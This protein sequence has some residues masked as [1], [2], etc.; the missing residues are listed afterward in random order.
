MRALADRRL[1]E[2]YRRWIDRA[3]A[4]PPEVVMLPRTIDVGGDA[5]LLVALTLPMG[6]VG[7]FFLMM[8]SRVQPA[9]DGWPPFLFTGLVGVGLWIAPVLL[10]RR[11]VRTVGASADRQR[12]VLRQGIFIGAEGALVRM[13]PDSC[14]PI[15]ADR[16]VS[17]KL[18]Q[19]LHP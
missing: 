15:P 7:A 9:T 6:V 1:P 11:L 4:L 8:A 12:G 10:L 19:P 13:E 5:V 14:H 16:F 2:P 18:F 3:I 17:A